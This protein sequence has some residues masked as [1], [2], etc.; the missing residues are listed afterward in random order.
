MV[1][2]NP[3]FI[4]LNRTDIPKFENDDYFITDDNKDMLLQ[5]ITDNVNSQDNSQQSVGQAQT[6]TLNSVILGLQK[7]LTILKDNDIDTNTK[8]Q[9]IITELSNIHINIPKI[10][11]DVFNIAPLIEG[12]GIFKSE[13]QDI[14]HETPL[15]DQVIEQLTKYLKMID[16][17]LSLYKKDKMI[18]DGRIERS[19]IPVMTNNSSM[20]LT[21]QEAL[22][23]TQNTSGDFFSPLDEFKFQSPVRNDHIGDR[24]HNDLYFEAM[25]KQYEGDRIGQILQEY[26]DNNSVQD[27]LEFIQWVF[28]TNYKFNDEEIKAIERRKY[29]DI[30]SL[31]AQD[32]DT[33]KTQEQYDGVV[34]AHDYFANH[35]NE[36]V[37]E[38]NKMREFANQQ[39]TVQQE[40]SFNDSNESVKP[41]EE[42]DGANNNANDGDAMSIDQTTIPTGMPQSN[43]PNTQAHGVL[44]PMLTDDL[45]E[46]VKNNN[47]DGYVIN[48]IHIVAEDF[49]IAY[50]HDFTN[51]RNAWTNAQKKKIKTQDQFLQIIYNELQSDPNHKN[52]FNVDNINGLGKLNN[53]QLTKNLNTI[54]EIKKNY[55][56]VLHKSKLIFMKTNNSISLLTGQGKKIKKHTM[57]STQP[58][59]QNLM[60]DDDLIKYLLS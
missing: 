46:I 3:R 10:V 18:M 26:Y 13:L 5:M 50:I 19:A 2:R 55:N 51:L 22:N 31:M 24:Q 36:L 25:V 23:T 60:I 21:P 29:A 14:N 27:A 37:H 58:Q 20:F 9:T 34:V 53:N 48:C 12:F 1:K 15:D 11:L 39:P 56:A 4:K 40:L 42:N 38:I 41:E 54:V 57:K 44:S 59:K 28:E 6:Y 52:L 7:I 35:S 8:I 30:L 17:Q 47:M 16:L 32:N 45:K 43:D 49:Y 33:I